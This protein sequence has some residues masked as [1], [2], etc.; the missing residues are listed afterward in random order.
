MIE[1]NFLGP[2]QITL[3]GRSLTAGLR[4][5]E[6]ALL[7]Y[8]AVVGEASRESVVALLWGD[9]GEA[10]ARHN[11]SVALDKI[12]DVAPGAVIRHGRR[13]IALAEAVWQASDVQQFERLIRARR[14]E[15]AVALY[16]GPFL[17]GL[18]PRNAAG[19]E[20][21][22]RQQE[23]H[24]E[25]LALAALAALL[26]RAEERRDNDALERHAQRVLTIDPL[27]EEAY[28]RLMLALARSGRFNE[29]LQVYDACAK[30]LR[31]ELDVTPEAATAALHERIVLARAAPR[32]ALPCHAAPFVGRDRELA[33]ATARL[34]SPAGQLLTLLGPGG[35]GKTRLAIELARRLGPSFLHGAVYVTLE[36]LD[37]PY[38][39]ESLLA[40]VAAALGL[41]LSAQ[42][43]RT[44]IT[45]FLRDR[46][47]LLVVDNFESFVP[48]ATTLTAI[49]REA[50]Q[51]RLLVT[52]RQRLDLPDEMV[53]RVGGL[54]Y[55]PEEDDNRSPAADFARYDAVTLFARAVAR[56]DA[57]F[58]PP[59][60]AAHVA[61]ICRLV[62]GLP[63]AIEMVAPWTLS[64]SCAAIADKLAAGLPDLLAYER[65][66]PDRHR[67]LHVVFEHSW[68]AL[69]AA[70]QRVFRRLAVI[71]GVF[72]VEAA[73]AI[74]GATKLLL[75]SLA[76]KSLIENPDER[77]YA[78]HPLVR[79]FALEKLVKAGELNEISAS[80]FDYF[81]RYAVSRLPDLHGAGQLVALRQLEEQFA[82][83]RA[84]WR[85]GAEHAPANVLEMLSDS[86]VRLCWARTWYRIGIEVLQEGIE[87]L[88]RRGEEYLRNHLL[89][90][91][92]LMHYHLGNYDAA[93]QC[94][95][96]A[97]WANDGRLEA[98]ALFLIASINYDQNRY[99]EAEPLLRRS[100]ELNQQN[101]ALD[102]AGDVL[103]R[104]GNL[105]MLRTF[106]SPAGKI[107]YKPPRAFVNEH[108]WPTSNQKAGIEAAIRY[109]E[110]ALSYFSRAGSLGGIAHGRGVIGVAH[111]TLHDYG[112]AADA[113]QEA[114][115]LF[116]QLDSAAE[117]AD[118]LMW[119]A[120]ARHHQG[121]AA[122][123][124]PI[125]HEA[126]RLYLS[127]SADKGVL[128]CL[129]KYSLHVWS[130]D[131]Q[132]FIP[133]AI[134]A[135]VAQHPHAGTR[136]KVIAE[137]WVEN[138]TGFMG[139]DEGEAAV[140]KALTFGRQQTL[141]GLVGYLLGGSL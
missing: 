88:A 77:R 32:P 119:L 128:D 28:R 99:D 98:L 116:G 38:T 118:C 121:R 76:R 20:E 87:P 97:S 102:A 72:T 45:G 46:E 9:M 39:R 94:A 95:Q 17:D 1:L 37:A 4:R 100:L 48:V 61:R 50:R 64:Q 56:L 132:H 130:A 18:H 110:E 22:H 134:N 19:F 66:F 105:S 103:I 140:D 21:W 12:D 127:A 92:G 51:V 53:Y 41:S 70:E 43:T 63:L 57:P 136:M 36:P 79:A 122:E 126:L 109:F 85:Y 117:E 129:Q 82:N 108:R 139:Q 124:R 84:A 16:R 71:A 13:F 125:F 8:L 7:A 29:A 2:A 40:A 81:S 30:L 68:A 115:R 83:I 35:M 49:L 6:I 52:S 62:E 3:A 86:I 11:L 141:A 31:Q 33:E 106:F 34:L 89:L 65:N 114:A 123:A 26:Q 25:H 69:P 113:F 75:D 93:Q 73:E 112:A 42:D 24:Y 14:H 74:A 137:E 91:Q 138:I 96:A 23:H 60:D 67:S 15:Q 80:H 135:F 90:H 27:H 54:S 58:D 131:K 104:L 44:Q 47:L 107:P 78:Y 111:Y 120:W 5:K 133:L 10:A 59:A 101:E 55:P